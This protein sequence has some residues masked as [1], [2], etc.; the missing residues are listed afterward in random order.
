LQVTR[1]EANLYERFSRNDQ[2]S[3]TVMW[4]YSA[5]FYM[6]GADQ[7]PVYFQP[8][9]WLTAPFTILTDSSFNEWVEKTSLQK[10]DRFYKKGSSLY[11]Q[12]GNGCHIEFAPL[13]LVD[14]GRALC[15]APP[16]EETL[17]KWTRDLVQAVM[18]W[19]RFEGLAG[20]L[21]FL[22]D[23]LW[24]G[25]AKSKIPLSPFCRYALPHIDFLLNST[26]RE[27]E[28]EFLNALGKLVG[29]GPGLTPA[30]DDLLT[31][32]LA[33]HKI[34]SSPF[35]KRLKNSSRIRTLLPAIRSRTTPVASELLFSA[36]EGIFP[37]TIHRIFQD[38]S[39]ITSDPSPLPST[40]AL[41][42]VGHSTGTDML[43][44]IIL[45]LTT[46]H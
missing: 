16:L 31:G 25:A 23:R 5:G 30:G 21:T 34:L 1:L 27:N 36:L 2:F 45:G 39:L 35:W 7:R 6:L 40:S 11:R 22:D 10:G 44:G 37:E 4:I 46:I 14:L 29:L 17:R 26:T 24:P 28:E 19:G 38:L 43:V 9:R 41:L 20:A 13:E 15:S 33:S 8:G 32:F 42:G 18:G 3:G 12:P